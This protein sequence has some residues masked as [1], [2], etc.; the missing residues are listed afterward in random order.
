MNSTLSQND[1]F[2]LFA[3]G[4]APAASSADG[5]VWFANR[6]CYSVGTAFPLAVWDAEVP[7]VVLMTKTTHSVAFARAKNDLHRAL[8]RAGVDVVFV[9]CVKAA[10]YE[11]RNASHRPVLTRREIFAA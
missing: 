8:K 7:G 4:L 6:V 10:A 1:V 5:M 11:A 2:A 9:T 3:A